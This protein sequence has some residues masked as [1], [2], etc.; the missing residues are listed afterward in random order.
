MIKDRHLLP[1][2][3]EIQ[4]KIR[5]AKWFMKLDITDIY[6]RL[7]IVEGEEWKT[8]F[9]IKYGHYEYLVMPFGLTNA[10]A[11]FQRFINEALGEI[12][13]VFVIAYLDDILIFLHNLKEHVQ[14]VQAVLEK[15]Q[16]AEVRLKL[17]KCEFHV[18][19]TEFLGYWI[20]TEGIQAEEGKVKAIQEWPEPTNLKELQQFIR[21][22][23]YY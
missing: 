17:K 14:H 16:K 5:E 9:R 1:L 11:S 7:R 12:L 23:N 19:E 2:I 10:P 15:L 4:D 6:H 8:A 18:Q 13:D 3:T 22:L 21:L 20:S